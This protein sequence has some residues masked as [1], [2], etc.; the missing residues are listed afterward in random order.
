[1]ENI[2]NTATMKKLILSVA[3]VLVAQ[4]TFAATSIDLGSAAKYTPYDP[5]MSPV[6]TVLAHLNGQTPTMDQVRRLMWIGRGFRYSF[7][8]PYTAATPEETA[9][10]RSG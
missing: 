7:T 6:K 3:A 4:I 1:M 10:T 9:A 2:T 5:Y 8:S